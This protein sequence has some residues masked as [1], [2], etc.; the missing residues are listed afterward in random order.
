MVSCNACTATNQT[1]QDHSTL[2]PYRQCKTG[3]YLGNG[4]AG[5]GRGGECGGESVTASEHLDQEVGV[6]EFLELV[7]RL[8]KGLRDGVGL[9]GGGDW[10]EILKKG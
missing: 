8:G 10:G 9:F 3:E 4:V 2:P 5:L 1:P 6:I 7:K